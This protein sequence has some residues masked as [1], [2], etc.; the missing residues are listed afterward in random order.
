MVSNTFLLFF[1]NYISCLFTFKNIP[2]HLPIFFRLAALTTL[3]NS[4]Q[5]AYR[6]LLSQIDVSNHSNYNRLAI[7][8]SILIARQCFQLEHFVMEV[9]IKSLIITYGE[10]QEGISSQQ[11]EVGASLTCHL[12]L[13]LFQSSR[14][15]SIRGSIFQS[16]VY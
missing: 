10:V 13:M 3:C 12:L 11:T 7:F 8:V 2:I 16:L 9:A 1:V 14:C 6:D 5:Q 15:L 4:G